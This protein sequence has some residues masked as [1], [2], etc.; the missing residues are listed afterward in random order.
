[1]KSK[2]TDDFEKEK[3]DGAVIM[4]ESINETATEK[5]QA[6]SRKSENKRSKKNE[7]E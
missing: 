7:L 1:M 5:D 2:R 6:Q 4:K 3:K